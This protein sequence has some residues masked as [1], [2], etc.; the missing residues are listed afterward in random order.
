MKPLRANKQ[1]EEQGR[2][3]REGSDAGP[4]TWWR[5]CHMEQQPGA[6]E[7]E[8]QGAKERRGRKGKNK[9]FLNWRSTATKVSRAWSWVMEEVE[10]GGEQNCAGREDD[11]V[12]GVAGVWAHVAEQA[13]LA[14]TAGPHICRDDGLENR[15]AAELRRLSGP[16]GLLPFL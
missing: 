12:M 15:L 7:E 6:A 2:R 11:Q 16:S 14:E 13:S 8:E 5:E 3:R 1:E 4:R 10:S 9:Q